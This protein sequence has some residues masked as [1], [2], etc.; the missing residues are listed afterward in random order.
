MIN[1]SIASYLGYNQ[2]ELFRIMVI[3]RQQKVHPS[4]M[5]YY[6]LIIIWIFNNQQNGIFRKVYMIS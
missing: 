2:R 3:S 5:A 6:K 1:N 4:E